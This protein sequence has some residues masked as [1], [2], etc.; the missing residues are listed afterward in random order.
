MLFFSGGKA[1]EG[2]AG[3]NTVP[4]CDRLETIVLIGLAAMILLAPWPYG[5]VAPWSQGVLFGMVALL[6]AIWLVGAAARGELVWVR[7]RV[8][9]LGA[10][11]FLWLGLALVPLPRAWVAAFSPEAAR[12]H[13]SALGNG[14]HLSQATLSIFPHGTEVALFRLLCL[15][16]VFFLIVQTFR[17]KRPLVA[18]AVV[19]VVAAGLELAYGGYR[20]VTGTTCI[21]WN[22]PVLAS[23]ALAGS[24][25]DSGQ[26]AS[27]LVVG[28]S[29]TM[30][31]WMA[32]GGARSTSADGRGPVWRRR[33]MLLVIGVLLGLGICFTRSHAGLLS[34]LAAVF[35]FLLC[36]GLAARLRPRTL[37]LFAM[38]ALVLSAG[39]F[40]ALEMMITW[41]EADSPSVMPGWLDRLDLYRSACS[42]VSAFFWT[43]AE[44]GPLTRSFPGSSPA[45]SE[46]RWPSSWKTTGSSSRAR[47]GFQGCCWRSGYSRS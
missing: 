31:F 33:R 16:G 32:T 37:V 9:L 4:R 11:L 23:R 40:I 47:P 44:S 34:T 7:S 14:E 5:S 38:V 39:Q 15:A 19:I 26:L 43:G 10:A 1:R 20:L 30:G 8:W 28:L 6:V 17:R 24:F 12:A 35:F 21:F 29:I 22:R 2:R 3:E 45:V 13:Q 42:L 36:V 46:T 25:L 41:I 18:V 27:L